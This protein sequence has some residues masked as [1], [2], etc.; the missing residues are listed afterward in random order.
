MTLSEAHASC[1]GLSVRPADPAGDVRQQ[2]VLRRWAMRYCPWVGLDGDDGLVLD[3]SG[4]AHLS[5]GEAALLADIAGRMQHAG[6]GVR[7]GLADTRGAAWALS[8][9]AP[10]IIPPGA[11]RD[12]LAPLPVAALRIPADIDTA[13]QRLGLRRIGDVLDAARAPLARRFGTGLLDRLDQAL[14]I[15]PEP[16]V[17]RSAPPHYAVRLTLPEPIGL[18]SDVMAGLDRLLSRL[19]DKLAA[20]EMGARSLRLGLR[21]VDGG[22]TGVALRLAAP[23][24]DPAR[25]APLFLRDVEG[26]DAGFGID[27]LRLQAIQ[28]EPMLA[29]QIGSGAEAGMRLDT[30]ITRI[31][32][33][34]GLDNVLRFQPV[35]SHL[36]ERA[37]ALVPAADSAPCMSWPRR[38]ARPLRIFPPEPIR[39]TGSEPPQAFRWR[40][41]AFTTA[42]STGPERI[43][44]EW[45]AEDAEWRSGLR[46]YWRVETLQGRRLWL[47]HTPQ[48]PGWFV[49]GEFL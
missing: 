11:A 39:A 40:R 33:R 43:A 4:S 17:P 16:I 35:D 18:V 34:V 20:Q 25:I 27:Q 28:V 1:P 19:C 12:E 5:G 32:T 3:I 14:D 6:F 42:R 36:P 26:L 48:A 45:W 49:Q 37:F 22:W 24:R 44:P 41:M 29:A 21:R 31:G 47:F 15:A 13:L 46:D 30:L 8:H 9:F 23:M 38:P 10:G 2:E 7:L